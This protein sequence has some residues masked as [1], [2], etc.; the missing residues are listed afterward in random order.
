MS[1]RLIDSKLTTI[2]QVG[3]NL[4]KYQNP[5]ISV[6]FYSDGT[7]VNKETNKRI[8]QNGSKQYFINLLPKKRSLNGIQVTANSLFNALI[9]RNHKRGYTT[10]FVDK[11]KGYIKD[12][13]ISI[14]HSV[15][16]VLDEFSKNKKF[17]ISLYNLNL[18]E[19]N[20]AISLLIA[21]GFKFEN[22]TGIIINLIKEG[23]KDYAKGYLENNN[24]IL[25]YVRL[26]VGISK[27]DT[28]HVIYVINKKLLENSN[29]DD[30]NEKII[31]DVKTKLLNC[32]IET[33]STQTQYVTFDNVI[34][35]NEEAAKNHIFNAS[36]ALKLS[37]VI[38]DEIDDIKKAEE[39]FNAYMDYK[40]GKPYMNFM[41]LMNGLPTYVTKSLN[42]YKIN[43]D[44]KY[45]SKSLLDNI[46]TDKI[47]A[48]SVAKEI[49]NIIKSYD[50][51]DFINLIEI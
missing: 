30:S 14:H 34:Y 32:S 4:Y 12:N 19:F 26:Y 6:D 50:T 47:S 23:S 51:I 16:T 24:G 40:N 44:S 8:N 2:T 15:K 20:E 10:I 3:P 9:G 28:S 33:L 22:G 17:A 42:R 45:V 38:I 48:E 35:D 5:K 36:V 21:Y 31:G 39:I 11:E 1:I 49:D 25:S 18:Q 46:Y 29:N 41:K 37:K 27:I 7:V 13:T 43:C